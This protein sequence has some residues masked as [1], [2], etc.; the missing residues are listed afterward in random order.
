MESTNRDIAEHGSDLDKFGFQKYEHPELDILNF[1]YSALEDPIPSNK[2]FPVAVRIFT[3][4]IRVTSRVGIVFQP[5]NPSDKSLYDLS[6]LKSQIVAYRC[7]NAKSRIARV[8]EI[9]GKNG[10]PLEFPK[11][12]IDGIAFQNDDDLP[13]IDVQLNLAFPGVPGMWTVYY[14]ATSSNKLKFEEW[15]QYISRVTMSP[16]QDGGTIVYGLGGV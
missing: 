14:H 16:L 9:V 2:L 5:K 11:S 1:A 13:Y 8:G 10:V 3:P 15:R 6:T 7:I 4:D 12:D